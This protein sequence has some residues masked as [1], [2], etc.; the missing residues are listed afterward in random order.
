MTD[1]PSIKQIKILQKQLQTTERQ[2][3]KL[4]KLSELSA[5]IVELDQSRVGRL[6]RMDAMQQQQMA[7]AGKRRQQYQLLQ[8]SQALKK[9]T[10]NDY[11]YCIECGEEIAYARLQIRPE[12]ELCVACQN[13]L[14]Q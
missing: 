13:Q 6:S 7:S 11:G 14:E 12:S 5:D 10:E 8:I 9:I 4:L 1:Y 2:L 3:T